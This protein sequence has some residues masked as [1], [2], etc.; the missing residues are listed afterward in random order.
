MSEMIFSLSYR[1]HYF[2]LDSSDIFSIKL[3]VHF[4]N[5]I[6]ISCIKTVETDIFLDKVDELLKNYKR[7]KFLTFIIGISMLDLV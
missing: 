2:F 6:P 4:Y 7:Y 1:F 3:P 5:L